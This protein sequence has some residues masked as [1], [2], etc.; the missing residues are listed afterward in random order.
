ME[1]E[2]TKDQVLFRQTTRRFL[3]Q[4]SP[5]SHVRGLHE[6]GVAFESSYWRKGGELGWT[7]MLVP[8]SMG[9]GTIAGAGLLDL[10]IVAEEIGRGVAP[11]PL[12]STNVVLQT[13]SSSAARTEV[14]DGLLRGV[15]A[16]A[17]AFAEPPPGGA[18]GAGAT[19]ATRGA[20][21]WT[22]RGERRLVLDAHS[23]DWILVDAHTD[24]GLTQFLVATDAD[25]VRVSPRTALDLVRTVGDVAFD[26]VMLVD[27]AVVGEP[28]GAVEALER[29]LHTALVLQ[30]AET[31]GALDRVLAFTLEY[32]VDRVSF[33]RPI[34]SYQAIK[35]RLAD[36]KMRLEACHA[37]ADASA[38]AVAEGSPRAAELV[39]V[40]KSYIGAHAPS[41]VQDCV[42]IHGGIGVTW[43]HDLH[44]YLRRV[45]QN[46]AL[47]GGVRYHRERLAS[48]LG[49]DAEG[50]TLAW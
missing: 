41:M 49:M 12:L 48:L 35:H 13:L 27:A 23:A 17:W 22:L 42:Q 10:K 39:S 21:G 32:A 19:V 6:R 50:P 38:H 28:G 40:A 46:A 37:T 36:L 26:D 44:L 5:L 1:L 7:T 45:T 15:T 4:E 18:S 8:E 24:I 33:G 3:D 31:V 11:G 20:D 29:Q 16:A 47:F 34:G 9:G 2:P 25:G 30:N 14:V 43:D